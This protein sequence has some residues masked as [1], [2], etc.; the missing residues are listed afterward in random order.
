MLALGALWLCFALGLLTAMASYGTQAGAQGEAPSHWPLADDRL[1]GHRRDLSTLVLFA[2]PLCPC[3]RA[4]L[5]ELESITN[6]FSAQVQTHVLFFT[7]SDAQGSGTLW[8]NS[9]LRS[10]AARL[11]GTT[12]HADIDGELSAYFGAYTSGHVLLYDARGNLQYAGG[13]TASRGHTGSN[14]GRS[15]IVTALARSA[16][17]PERRADTALPAEPGTV[18]QGPVFGCS[19]F[20]DSDRVPVATQ[21]PIAE[22][23]DAI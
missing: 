11:P 5:W 7:P 17:L 20:D 14:P 10:I 22:R 19:I 18:V 12:V 21:Y 9:D 1:S 23:S 16:D 6:R 4:S 15:A 13:I 3:T 2:H 8:Q